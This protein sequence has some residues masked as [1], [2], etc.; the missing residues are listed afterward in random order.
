[1]C[2]AIDTNPL[3]SR[4]V[5]LLHNRYRLTGGE[6]RYVAQLTELLGRRAA[7]SEAVERASDS[8]G[9][10]IAGVALVRGGISHAADEVR[11]ALQKSP[12]DVVHAHNIHP[13]FGWRALAAAREAGAAVVLHLHN[14]R[15]FCATGI[16]FRDGSDCTSCAPRRTWNGAMHNCRGGL[17]EAA[18]YA[19]GLG[20]WQRRLIESVDLFVSPTRQL[21]DDLR[22]LDVDLPIEVL[23]TWLP[24]SDFAEHSLCGLGDYGFFAGRVSAEKGI[25]VAIE[26][27]AKSGVAVRVAGDGPDLPAAREH[28]ARLGAPVEF[29]GMLDAREMAEMRLGA[30]FALLPSIW[31]E[32]L[33]FAALEARAAGLPLVVSRRGGLPEL[34]DPDLVFPAGDATALAELMTRLHNDVSAREQ[35]G[36]RALSEARE[37]FS[38]ETFGRRLA[39]VYDSAIERRGR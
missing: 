37:R 29:L 27:A 5:L 13:A 9:R 11:A 26:A 1:M 24:D 14:Y 30:A 32:V 25:F 34:T 2:A 3:G 4:R 10:G 19:A 6:E 22:E 15:L 35:A 21:A 33:P 7:S 12:A 16:A 31:R 36:E 18:A 23:P 17:A 28:A 39:A 20:L 8:I 38:E